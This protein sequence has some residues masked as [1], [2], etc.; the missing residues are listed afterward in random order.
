LYNL[1][2]DPDIIRLPPFLAPLQSFI[3]YIISKRRAP[4]SIKAYESIGGGS[5]ILKYSNDQA[6]LIAKSLK[7][8]YDLDVNTYI[9]IGTHSQKKH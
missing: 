9:G 7:D 4:K 8:K 3:A 5:P 2:A 6:A 1:F